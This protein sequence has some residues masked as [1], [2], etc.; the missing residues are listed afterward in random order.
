MASPPARRETPSLFPLS[1]PAQA[2]PRRD[3]ANFINH[4]SGKTL[5]DGQMKE[6]GSCNPI[7]MGD[8]P[9]VDNMISTVITYPLPGDTVA[10]NKDFTVSIQTHNLATGHFTNPLVTYYSAPQA[11][12]ESGKVLGH[13]HLVIQE[14][15]SLRTTTPPPPTEFAFFAGVNDKSEDG[16][17][18]ANVQGGLPAGAYRLCTLVA[19]ANHQPVLMPV[20]QRG[21]QDDCVRFEVVEGTYKRE[22]NAQ[23]GGVAACECPVNDV[24]P[25]NPVSP[26]G[27]VAP[28][29]PTPGVDGELGGNAGVEQEL[30]GNDGVDQALSGGDDGVAPEAPVIDEELSD[31]DVVPEAPAGDVDQALGGDA[32]VDQAL[33]GG[34]DSV[35]PEA[36]VINEELSGDVAP[37]APTTGVDGELGGSDGAD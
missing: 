8:I 21:G 11:L 6:G 13:S 32:G 22:E 19:A 5:T 1:F 2:D 9:S 31:G 33:G 35:A 37:E 23:D 18:S 24:V 28:E 36:P 30:G 14:L 29:A 10:A 25:E 34:D 16:V 27:D 17:L 4:C 20:P 26:E 12:D 3:K 15:D 7:S